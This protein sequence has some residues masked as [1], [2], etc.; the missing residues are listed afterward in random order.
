[1]PTYDF[2]KENND[3]KWARLRNV[4]SMPM[5]DFVAYGK[6]FSKESDDRVLYGFDYQVE[7]CPKLAAK[8]TAPPFAETCLLQEHCIPN[9]PGM[10]FGWPT[11]MMGVP[12]TRSELHSDNNGLAFW[13]AVHHGYACSSA[14]LLAC[15]FASQLALLVLGQVRTSSHRRT[16]HWRVL[17]QG[18]NDHLTTHVASAD[19]MPPATGKNFSSVVL[20]MYM[21]GP[22]SYVPLKASR[23]IAQHHD[24]ITQHHTASHSITQH[25]TA[26]HSITQH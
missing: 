4:G 9:D 12:G 2:D 14:P 8:M 1:M 16:K 17:P 21:K 19:Y 11:M 26:S 3:Q 18:H 5:K 15:S 10:K 6:N 25:H 22:H 24:R 7:L 13:M 20:D 23:C